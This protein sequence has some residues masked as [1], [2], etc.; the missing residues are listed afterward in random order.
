MK[1][2]MKTLAMVLV[3]GLSLPALA[4]FGMGGPGGPGMGKGE[5]NPERMK[6][7]RAKALRE[8]VGLD[9]AKATEVEKVLDGFHE[10]R[11][12]LHQTLRDNMKQLRALLKEDSNDQEAY[13]ALL[14]AMR[15]AHEEMKTLQDEQMEALRSVLTPKEQAKMI[16]TMKQFKKKAGKFMKG[17]HGKGGRG[18][19]GGGPGNGPCDG[20]C[21]WADDLE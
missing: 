20:P 7:F 16:L 14:D 13:A 9:E 2:M 19:P 21:P 1:T 11:F 10:R 6:A 3:L 8:A 5:P 18:G 17:R 12:E 4:Q 15:V